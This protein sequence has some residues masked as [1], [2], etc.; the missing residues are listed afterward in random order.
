MTGRDLSGRAMLT[1]G[2]AVVALALLSSLALGGAVAVDGSDGVQPASTPETD[3]ASDALTATEQADSR[4]EE[5]LNATATVAQPDPTVDTPFDVTVTVNRSGKEQVNDTLLITEA[6]LVDETRDATRGQQDASKLLRPDGRQEI[7]FENVEIEDAGITEFRTELEVTSLQS[8]KTE[9]VKQRVDVAVS[10]PSPVVDLRVE[11]APEGTDRTL[12]VAVGNPLTESIQRLEVSVTPPDDA[13]F[14]VV[15]SDGVV[16][17]LEPGETQELSFD[18]RGASTGTHDLDVSLSYRSPDGEFWDITRTVPTEFVEPSNPVTVD[19]ADVSVSGAPTG[20]RISGSVVSAGETRIENIE[21][22]AADAPGVDPARPEP[23]ALIR[24]LNRTTATTFEL[25]AALSDN[26]TTVPLRLEYRTAG[27]ERTTTVEIQYNGP[28]N[29]NPVQLTDV[30]TV[31]GGTVTISGSVAN[32]WE[33]D[34]TGVTVAVADADGVDPGRS[35][36]FF[37]GPVEAGSFGPFEEL[38]AQL[39]GDRETVPVEI[40]YVLDGSQ[41]STVEEVEHSTGSAGRGTDVGGSGGPDS[42]SG[43]SFDPGTDGDGGSDGSLPGTML[44]GAGAV[45]LVGVVGLVIYRRR[46]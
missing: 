5:E 17:V 39:T 16:P 23:Q 8:V 12:S 15:D 13:G 3:G 32:T 22:T 18:V 37:V 33:A 10:L 6:T 4:I 1:A 24:S 21:I 25:T 44:L 38:T 40:S 20:V 26:R 36:E 11:P 29:V 42:S 9:T 27:T 43:P 41:Y 7:T 35:P 34:V 14:Q 46:Q 45:A 19:V 2:V 28:R 31:G 30:T